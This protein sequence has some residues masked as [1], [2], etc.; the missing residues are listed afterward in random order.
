MREFEEGHYWVQLTSDSRPEVALHD[1]GCWRLH[2]R[3]ERSIPSR[4][5]QDQSIRRSAMEKTPLSD[6]VKGATD[7]LRDGATDLG[8]RT[9]RIVHEN[10]PRARRAI[11]EGYGEAVDAIGTLAR[12]RSARV[13]ALAGALGIAI[14]TLL[15]RR[16]S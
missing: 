15:G 11:T 13:W 10:A 9:A 16:R 12:N 14:G 6:A 8:E 1:H 2:G 7:R 5:G 3:A 4:V